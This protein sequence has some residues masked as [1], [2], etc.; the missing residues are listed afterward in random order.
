MSMGF[1]KE[2][3][4]KALLET[5]N[6]DRALNILTKESFNNKPFNPY[7]IPEGYNFE[8]NPGH[9]DCFYYSVLRGLQ[10][11]FGDTTPF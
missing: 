4:E 1:D 6:I 3:V 8:E 10:R 7:Q 11:L 5:K 2:K 9:G